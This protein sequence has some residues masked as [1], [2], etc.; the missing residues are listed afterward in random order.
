ME[1]KNVDAGTQE[2]KLD[3]RSLLKLGVA[4]TAALVTTSTPAAKASEKG[5]GTT[6]YDDFPYEVS[7]DYKRFSEYNSVFSSDYRKGIPFDK[8]FYDD[9]RPGFSSSDYALSM[10]STAVWLSPSI[11]MNVVHQPHDSLPEPYKFPDN[12]TAHAQIKRAA[13]LFGADVVGITRRDE[14]WD[15][16]HV[17]A[18]NWNLD[19][20]VVPWEEALPGFEPKTV[21]VLGWE[22]GYEALATAPSQI[23]D[24]TANNAYSG[25]TYVLTQMTAYLNHLGYQ[26]APA[27]NGLGLNVPYAVAAGLGEA[28][29]MGLLQ[30]YKY[31]PRLRIAKLYTDLEFDEYLDKPVSYGIQDFCE[32]CMHC[33]D[34]CPSN[35][36]THDI[37]TRI[38]T[39]EDVK[40]RPFTNPGVK[41]WHFDAQK[42]HDYWIDSGTG[43]GTCIAACPYNKPDFWHHRLIDR[44]NTVLPGPLHKFMAQMDLWHGYGNMFDEKAPAVFWDPKGRSYDGLK[45]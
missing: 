27:L 25:L 30:N 33:A 13:R 31:G 38:Y 15:Y 32:N 8:P 11:P 6:V 43:C 44:L 29:R 24:A 21:I 20:D 1:L 26:A 14:R 28:N 7:P 36:L 3:R 4:G 12:A 18:D 40:D 16:S 41:K 35:A 45:G 23:S 42:C 5:I 2:P 22:M 34:K 17:Y 9:S 39:A 10:A 19:V 37:K